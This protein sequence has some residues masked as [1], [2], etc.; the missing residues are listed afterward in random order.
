[1]NIIQ[2]ILDFDLDLT[3]RYNCKYFQI[4]QMPVK[5]RAL[6]SD[7]NS[8]LLEARID[9]ELAIK[10][11]TQ[12]PK[13]SITLVESSIITK[14]IELSKYNNPILS[15]GSISIMER[16]LLKKKKAIQF[17]CQQIFVCGEQ[18]LALKKFIE[19]KKDKFYIM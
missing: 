5:K 19:Q 14:M 18:R 8:R 12:L 4:F 13:E 16:V 3:V 17:F 15:S 7:E 1:M 9:N 11:I 6:I 2:L 10:F